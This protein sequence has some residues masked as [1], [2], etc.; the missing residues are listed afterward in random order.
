MD[1]ISNYIQLMAF[2]TNIMHSYLIS[3]NGYYMSVR[4]TTYNNKV[5]IK[6]VM[7]MLWK[8]SILI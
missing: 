1:V 8:L 3:G 2:K 4:T 7:G 6:N 5:V